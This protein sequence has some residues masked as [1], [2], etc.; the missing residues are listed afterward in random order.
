[1]YAI[2]RAGGQQFRA[3]SGDMLRVPAI[4]AEVGE[5][6][7]FDNVLLAGEGE[8]VKIG[9]P[10]LA[11]AQVRAEVVRHGRARKVIVFKRKRRK[12]YRRKYGHRQPFTEIRI[13]EIVV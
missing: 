3:E 7:T 10:A 2:F 6:V 4:A 8:E 9:G 5:T 13:Q 11:G 1:M 12:N